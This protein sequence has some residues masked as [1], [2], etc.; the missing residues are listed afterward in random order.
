MRHIWKNAANMEKCGALAK[1]A[2]HFPPH[3]EKD[4]TL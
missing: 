1:N 4:E 3:F 2:P